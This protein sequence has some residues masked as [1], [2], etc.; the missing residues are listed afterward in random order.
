[1]IEVNIF[2]ITRDPKE[3]IEKYQCQS[4]SEIQAFETAGIQVFLSNDQV[5]IIENWPSLIVESYGKEVLTFFLKQK[6]KK[7]CV[8]LKATASPMIC[9]NF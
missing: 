8:A 7:L 3:H 9:L 2:I 5:I 6:V 4:E 1:M